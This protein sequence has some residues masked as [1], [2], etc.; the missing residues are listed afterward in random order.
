MRKRNIGID[1]LRI[2]SMYMVM[3]LHT[4]SNG[5]F[6]LVHRVNTVHTQVIFLLTFLNIVAVDLFAIISGY[7]GLNSHH[8]TS[9]I[10]D[11]WL[12][13]VMYAY[14]IALAFKAFAPQYLTGAKFI[15][16]FLP[17]ITG[18]YWY[19][20][21]YLLLFI[22]MPLINAGIK[23]LSKNQFTILCI[24]LFFITSCLGFIKNSFMFNNGL[25][26]IWL[27]IMYIYGAYIKLYGLPKLNKIHGLITYFGASILGF[28]I[29][30]IVVLRKLGGHSY[31][32]GNILYQDW[33]YWFDYYAPLVVIATFG[34]FWFFV[35]LD[36]NNKK[37]IQIVEKISPLAFG[38]YLL[39]SNH[40]VYGWFA[41]AYDS[42][43]YNNI[44]MMIFLI[45]GTA[46]LWFAIGLI[47][48]FIR[49]TITQKIKLV[50]RVTAVIKYI[51]YKLIGKYLPIQ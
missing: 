25:S 42:Y 1:L 6:L 3:T 33:Y 26:G 18:Q 48:E 31:S 13:V 34:L 14:V 10:I 29:A 7:V 49:Q 39:Q 47:I 22:L 37:I 11:L 23:Q 46:L 28:I 2:L 16:S 4:M 50:Q 15:D 12:Q 35:N 36:I 21:G 24:V 51:F 20:N 32:T 9:R 27:I 44:F 43:Y 41:H 38:P 19:F 17:T 5:G 40:I 45:M 30:N 8:K